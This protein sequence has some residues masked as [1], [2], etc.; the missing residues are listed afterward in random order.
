MAI[1]IT[2]TQKRLLKKSLTIEELCGQDLTAGWWN[3]AGV[4][5]TEGD[6]PPY[7]LLDPARTGRGC[8]VRIDPTGKKSVFF[9]QTVPFTPHDFDILCELVGRACAVWGTSAIDRDGEPSTLAEL[10]RSRQEML[11]FSFSQ[12]KMA[13]T[14]RKS[15]DVLWPCAR[16]PLYPDGETISR[17]QSAVDLSLLEDYFHQ[18]QCGDYYYAKPRFYEND[19]CIMGVY[20]ITEGVDSI[21]PT[22]PFVPYLYHQPDLTVN[23]WM[24]GLFSISED[25]MLGVVPF[26]AFAEAAALKDCPA[27]D[28]K[29]VALA[30]IPRDRLLELA[31]KLKG[32]SIF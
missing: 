21:V 18:R 8:V 23:Q 13:L 20:S 26:G 9:R 5:E 15:G 6:G 2:V 31:G 22:E 28:A 29:H 11:D 24:A 10:L 7:V 25:R 12:L 14:A 4:L 16:Y 30:G 1:E 17:L 3:E 32:E 19:G 27:F